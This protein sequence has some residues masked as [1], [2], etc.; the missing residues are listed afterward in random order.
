M[1]L[2]TQHREP[3]L[4]DFL[5]DNEKPKSDA[6]FDVIRRTVGGYAMQL[7]NDRM[8][9]GDWP[10]ST[11][12]ITSGAIHAMT[13]CYRHRVTRNSDTSS[14]NLYFDYDGDDV[15]IESYL[16]LE[17][18]IAFTMKHEGTLRIRVPEWCDSAAMRAQVAGSGAAAKVEV[19]KGYFVIAGLAAGAHGEV[20]FPVAC[21]V[22]KE[23]VDGTEYT[24]T[25]IG[26]QIVDIQPR[27]VVSPLPF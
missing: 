23:I 24:T 14:V 26:N 4:R 16:P 15:T 3:E 17:G 9:E 11:L 18:R 19:D 5:R 7:P 8:R 13:E 1:L 10:L 12:D 21:K 20:T 6:E 22:E 25:W 2:P 27:G